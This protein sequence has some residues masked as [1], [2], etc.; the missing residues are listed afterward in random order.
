[1]RITY[2]NMHKVLRKLSTKTQWWGFP[3]GAVV[4]SPPGNAEDTRNVGLIPGLERCP[5]GGN[6]NAWRSQWTEESSGDEVLQDSKESDTTEHAHT[7]N[8]NIIS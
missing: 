2:V 7:L 8:A 4:K 1:M 3:G 5:G 6:N